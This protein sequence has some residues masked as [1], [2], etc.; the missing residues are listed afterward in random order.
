MSEETQ[1][2]YSDQDLESDAIFHFN[3]DCLLYRNVP[4]QHCRSAAVPNPNESTAVIHN[5]AR[6]T[7]QPC[8]TCASH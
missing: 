3:Q 6:Y 2:W 4:P 8:A 5:E 7:L 1:I